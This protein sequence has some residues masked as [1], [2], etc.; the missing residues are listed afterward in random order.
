MQIAKTFRQFRKLAYF[1]P[2][3]R[4]LWCHPHFNQRPQFAGDASLSKRAI[5]PLCDREIIDGVYA[6]KKSRRPRRLIALQMTNQ[7]PLRRQS[8]RSGALPFPL[9]DAIL[10]KVPHSRFIGLADG[11]R[12]LR[13]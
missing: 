10:A 4:L 5:Q 12:R 1:H 8:I 3:L 9:L 7:V 11:A 6:V 13:L 2:A